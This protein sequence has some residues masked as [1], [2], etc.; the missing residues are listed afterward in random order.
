MPYFFIKHYFDG[1]EIL[2]LGENLKKMVRM[3]DVFIKF[4]NY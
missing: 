1:T 4:L 2:T 3:V